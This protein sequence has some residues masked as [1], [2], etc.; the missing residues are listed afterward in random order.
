MDKITGIVAEFNPF[1]NGHKLLLDAA[2]EDTT[3]VVVMSGNWMQRGEPSFVDKWVRTEQALAG[4]ADLIVELPLMS[5]LQGADFFALGAVDILQR[6]G[7][8][9]I[10]FG[11]ESELDYQRISEIYAEKSTEMTA[12]MAALPELMS[13]PLKAEKA[14]AHFAG[15]QFDGNTPNHILGLAYAKAAAGTG[16]QLRTIQRRTR[17]NGTEL[18]GEIASATAIRENFSEAESFVPEH[19]RELLKKAPKTSWADFWELLRYKITV[20]ADL[21]RI[22][23]VNDELAHRIHSYVKTAPTLDALIEQVYTKRYTKGHIRRLL[24]YILLDIPREFVLPEPIHVLGF[25]LKGQKV[26][27]QARKNEVPICTR[28]GQH[29]WDALTQ[30]SDEVYRLGNPQ[31]PEQTY[32]RKPI[33]W[34]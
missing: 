6:L 5:A 18:A 24:C 16:I 7:V 30:R 8:D 28:I 17:Y 13:Y 4:G 3:K 26:L 14:W 20:T 10:L 11:T 33:I 15:V 19:S 2:G 25:T 9:E 32:S 12:Y 21:T 1:H 23:Q 22:Y 34:N 29:P 27:A 31:I